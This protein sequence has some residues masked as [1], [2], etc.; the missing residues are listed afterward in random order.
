MGRGLRGWRSP[1]STWRSEHPAAR[2]THV[3]ISTHTAVSTA[4]WGEVGGS[5]AIVTAGAGPHALHGQPLNVMPEPDGEQARA[6]QCQ[7]RMRACL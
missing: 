6:N 1:T 4:F 3:Q 5:A 7:R 2:P